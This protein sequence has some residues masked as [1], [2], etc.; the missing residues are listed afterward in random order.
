MRMRLL[1]GVLLALLAG[2][3]AAAV[4]SAPAGSPERVIAALLLALVLPGLAYTLLLT[5]R[6]S[7]ADRLLLVPALSMAIVVLD[8][9]GL[10]VV[11]THLDLR[12]WTVSIA[13]ITVGLC[14][15]GLFRRGQRFSSN[16]V[17]S[18]RPARRLRAHGRAAAVLLGASLSV[19][20][21]LA[22]ATLTTVSSVAQRDRR[23][24]FTQ[25][26]ALPQGAQQRRVAIGVFN[27]ESGRRTYTLQ[28]VSG[29]RLVY[30]ARF[31]LGDQ[32]TWSVVRAFPRGTSSLRIN[33]LLAGSHAVYRWVQL[34]LPV[35][36]PR[37]PAS[38][39]RARAARSHGPRAHKPRPPR[40]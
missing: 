9:V 20:A 26:W 17:G 31:T 36:P 2:G 18:L 6:Q 21:L 35:T 37:S 33:L 14:V 32:Q 4:L 23:N 8:S 22:A 1:R 30:S 10:Y 28:A 40:R 13:A 34:Y 12:A 24:R 7:P 39:G 15:L 5:S 16:G 11:K 25:L 3:C 38:H 29:P 27:H 19:A